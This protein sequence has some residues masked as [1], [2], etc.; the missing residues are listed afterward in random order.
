MVVHQSDVGTVFELTIVD[1]DSAVVDISTATRQILFEKPSGA[2]LTKTA[3]LVTDGTD[4]KMKYVTIAGD[5]TP[6]GFWFVQG[7][8]TIGLN[9]WHTDAL[10]FT[11]LPNLV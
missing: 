11:V 4:G 9:T 1:Q 7:V 3:A 2:T 8:V 5:L 6:A 10:A